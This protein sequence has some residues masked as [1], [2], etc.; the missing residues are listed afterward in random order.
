MSNGNGGKHPRKPRGIMTVLGGYD[1]DMDN[2]GKLLRK[3]L[4][5]LV[6]GQDSGADPVGDGTF[7]MHPSGDVVDYAER[8][9][10][11]KR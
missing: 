4:S 10:R 9:R 11:L 7:R 6:D 2:H 8:C 5:P 1:L 3:E